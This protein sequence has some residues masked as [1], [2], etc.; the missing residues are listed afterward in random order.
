MTREH[1]DCR[2]VLMDPSPLGEDLTAAS[3]GPMRELCRI[4][5]SAACDARA[6]HIGVFDA[7][8]RTVARAPERGWMIDSPHPNLRG[9]TIIA[10]LVLEQLG[11]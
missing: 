2:I 5:A 4:V 1:L 9:Q 3:H 6:E 10:R 8:L 11:W 7:F